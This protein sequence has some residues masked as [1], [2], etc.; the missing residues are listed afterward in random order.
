VQ[1]F[2]SSSARIRWDSCA[3]GDASITLVPDGGGDPIV[4]EGSQSATDIDFEYAPLL[5]DVE[6]DRPGT[7]YL[8]EVVPT[9]LEPGACYSFSLGADPARGGRFCTARP[10]GQAFRFVATGDTNPTVGP[11]PELFAAA[12]ADGPADF[13]A[14]LGDIQ[15]Y[16][17]LVESWA[18]WFELLQPMLSSA[19]FQP[20]IGN[21]EDEKPGEYEAYYGRL[22]ADAGFGGTSRYYRFESGGLWFF[23]LD[24]ESDL[25]PNSPQ[26]QWLEAELAA[27]SVQ[28]G[29]R[30]SIVYMHRPF[31]TVGD[32][33]SQP[34]LRA[35]YEPLFETQGV[36]LVLAGHMH[37]YE[38]FESGALVYV[39]SGG[40]GGAMGDI[41]ANVEARPD[42]AA[43]RVAASDVKHMTVLDVTASSID[44][45]AVDAA[46][47][48][49]DSFSVPLP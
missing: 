30:G 6:P 43:L 11:T 44:V 39:T 19:A 45:R 40:G 46:G 15:Y 36:R 27:A 33:A 35:Y 13:V 41:D 48:T 28:P 7:Y 9:G 14:H 1:R 29:F 37:G 26:G 47:G 21:H 3:P 25:S 20:S 10:T 18:R 42:E 23:A 31:I 16:S 5:D 2:D 22:F 4:V 8:S 17:A 12:V 34:A 38:R 32:S 49:L 24:T